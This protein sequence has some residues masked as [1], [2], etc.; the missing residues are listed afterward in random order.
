MPR[1]IQLQVAPEVAA[2]ESL[3]KVHIAKLFQISTDEIEHIIPL[4]RSIDARQ[5]AIKINYKVNV[6]FKGED[7]VV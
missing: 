2:N 1:E 7:F 4:K 5:K 6:F 3:L